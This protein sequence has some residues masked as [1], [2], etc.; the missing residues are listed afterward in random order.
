M[1]TLKYILKLFKTYPVIL[2]YILKSFIILQRIFTNMYWNNT[3]LGWGN[4]HL[5]YI[6][7]MMKRSVRPTQG[8]IAEEMNLNPGLLTLCP[9]LCQKDPSRFFLSSYCQT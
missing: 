6:L 3:F 7:H 2:P 1:Y 9:L 5:H 4:Y 8:V